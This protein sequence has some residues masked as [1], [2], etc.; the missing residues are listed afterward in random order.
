MSEPTIWMPFSLDFR[1]HGR[2]P[3]CTASVSVTLRNYRGKSRGSLRAS[4]SDAVTCAVSSVPVHHS[5]L[6]IIVL[7]GASSSASAAS[8]SSP[9]KCAQRVAVGMWTDQAKPAYPVA[10]AEGE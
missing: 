8:T 7:A 1:L 10:R 3:F 2:R 4:R 5:T 9:W 6:S